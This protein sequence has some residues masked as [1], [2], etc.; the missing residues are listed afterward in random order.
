MFEFAEGG[1]PVSKEDYQ[2]AE[3]PLR[4]DLLNAQFDLKDAGFSVIVLLTG[5]D[6]YG[7]E[8]VID[9]IHDWMD[10]RGLDTHIFEPQ[11]DPE[12][13]MPRLWRVWRS[14]P[15]RG[16]IGIFSGAWA[17]E[18]VSELVSHRISEEEF[19]QRAEHHRQFESEL[20]ADGTLILKFWLHLPKT[21][22]KRRLD[23]AERHP[24]R[25]WW[26]GRS[27]HLLYRRFDDL[28]P[29]AERYLRKTDTAESPWAV[30]DGTDSRA[31]DLAVMQR[32]RDAL[33]TRLTAPAPAP[34]AEAEAEAGAGA[35]PPPLTP[36]APGPLAA[37]DL[38]AVLEEGAFDAKRRKLMRKLHRRS[39]KARA[40]TMSTVVVMEGWDAAGKGSAIRRMTR[41]MDAALY[42]VIPVAAPTEEEKS[43]HYLWRF[44]RDLPRPGKM[45]IFDRSWY[46]RVL[47][48]RVEGFATEPEWRRAYAEINDFEEQL[49][50]HGVVLRKFW[51]HI[52]KEEQARRFEERR[53]TPYKKYKFTEEDERNRAKWDQYT[54]AV[55]EMLERTSTD[56]APWH[57]V[58]ANDKRFARIAVLREVCKGLKQGLKRKRRES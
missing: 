48:E 20:T 30:I 7:V 26:V 45:V 57:I 56:L 1:P 42:R 40:A 35:T 52:S 13:R 37:V 18:A 22:L 9:L 29:V 55:D 43:R 32:L 50:E 49:A 10:A 39:R 53:L 14:L 23:E 3:G 38:S 36:P 28:L 46:G 16:R 17:M 58:P 51:L 44:W 12:L 54:T 4:V 33:L 21:E 19:A 41:A 25:H 34:P 6:R 31:R 8:A 15:A 27:D 5:D 24:D 47:V 11:P 2:A